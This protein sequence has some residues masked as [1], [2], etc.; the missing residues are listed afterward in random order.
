[1]NMN[2]NNVQSEFI[3]EYIKK[4]NDPLF[5]QNILNSLAECNCCHNH[6]LN[7]PIIFSPFI[8][9]TSN[10]THSIKNCNCSCRHL[11]RHI[12]RLYPDSPSPP[13]LKKKYKHFS[14]TNNKYQPVIL[15]QM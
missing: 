1:M 8:Y 12:C 2:M 14:A 3:L 11:A 7:K 4:H 6:K 9:N 5:A 10:N 15:L 13:K